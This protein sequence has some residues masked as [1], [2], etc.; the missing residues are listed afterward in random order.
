MLRSGFPVFSF[1]ICIFHWSCCTIFFLSVKWLLSVSFCLQWLLPINQ[2]CSIYSSKI[3]R[4][5]GWK[6]FL[7]FQLIRMCVV[8]SIQQQHI[9]NITVYSGTQRDWQLLRVTNIMHLIIVLFR[10]PQQFACIFPCGRF[11]PEICSPK[12]FKFWQNILALCMQKR[13][14]TGNHCTE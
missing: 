1:G 12:W 3:L 13:H 6:F 5:L 10:S 9:Y 14:V 7:T 2:Y 8:V 11:L 4:L